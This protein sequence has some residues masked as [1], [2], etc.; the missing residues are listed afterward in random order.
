MCVY[1]DDIL[2]ATETETEHLRV[3]G[4]VLKCLAKAELRVKKH[5]CRFMVPAVPYLGYVVDTDGVRPLPEKI[6]A[7][8]Q[9]PT[10]KNVTELKS[11]LGLLTY[12]GKLL[13]NLSTHL[14][15]LYKLL[16]KTEPW[17]WT[18]AQ[19]KAFNESKELRKDVRNVS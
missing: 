18:S 11:Y 12:Y 1:I 7:I 9:A 3:L 6:K 2:I 14:A 19:D 17:K 4:E 16:N 10:P 8:R 5:K 13:S 15:P